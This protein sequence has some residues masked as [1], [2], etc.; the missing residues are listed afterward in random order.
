MATDRRA[1]L[2]R[3]ALGVLAVPVV[4]RAQ[5]ASDMPRIGLLSPASPLSTRS[6]S[7]EAFRQGLR[8]LGYVEGK[9][10]T[11]E[12]RTAEGKPERL[13]ALAEELVRLKVDV[14]VTYGELGARAAKEATATIPIVMAVIGEPVATGFAASLAR[15]GGNMT[16]LTNLASGL[17]HKR[18]ELLRQTLPRTEHIAVL[19]YP[20]NRVLDPIYWQ[21]AQSAAKALNVRLQPVE[22]GDA[23]EF[24][25]AFATMRRERVDGLLVLPDAF[26]WF[27]RGR[28]TGLEARNQLPAMHEAREFVEEGGLI[29]YGP[30]ITDL[31]RRAAGYVDKLLKGAKPGDLPI[32]QPTK[33]ELLINL[34]TAKTLG[35]TIPQPLLLRADELIQ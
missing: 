6:P 14:I 2:Y 12:L 24:E 10:I 16:G 20:P 26:F 19:R 33:F 27:N 22:V 31:F 30:S 8:E 17:E 35:L 9:N 25:S 29:S 5:S 7:H 11:I 34:K 23:R 32:E 3:V 15:P 28:V 1:F 4:A 21:E 13:R 18:L